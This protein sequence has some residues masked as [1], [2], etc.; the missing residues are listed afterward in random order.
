M[1]SKHFL[2]KFKELTS[3]IEAGKKNPVLINV[4]PRND[5]IKKHIPGS[6]NIPVQDLD[7]EAN[8]L[9]SQHDWIVV[10]CA[11]NT[12]DASHKAGEKL[13]KLGFSNVF[14]FSGGMDEWTNSNAYVCSETPS[15]A[16]PIKESSCGCYSTKK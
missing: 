4:L 2:V 1:L 16:Q 14:R 10:Y 12:C 6:I 11:N 5:F 15:C 7:K 8:K 3:M 9:F 13:I